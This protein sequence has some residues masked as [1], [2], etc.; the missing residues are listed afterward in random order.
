MSEEI[1]IK[2]LVY[3]IENIIKIKN[4]PKE[5]SFNTFSGIFNGIQYKSSFGKGNFANV[6]WI[7]FLGFNQEV[8][9]GIYPAILYNTKVSN[10]NFEICYGIS[11][12]NIPTNYW[13]NKFIANLPHSTTQ[14]Y[15]AS[16]LKKAYTINTINDLK[17]NL[18]NILNDIND[19]LKDFKENFSPI[20]SSPNKHYWLY[21]AGEKSYK[22]DEFYKEGI[23]ALNWD[24]LGNL[25]NYHAQD[26]IAKELQKYG[27]QDSYPMNNSK[28]NWE[29]AN[30]MNIGDIVYVKKGLEPILLGRG[31]V[32]SDYIYDDTRN[33][34]KSIRKVNWTHNGI[35]NVDFNELDIKQWNQ[36]TLN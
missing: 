8:T 18:S 13:N 20:Q 33:E 25:K 2:N 10:N 27:P 14:N 21:A 26:E 3:F 7:V 35:Y 31:V 22:W 5:A 12:Y 11:S 24:H 23:M 34:Y 28:A 15:H 6:P 32:T 36:K 29:F 30:E 4:N 19:I 16:F 17:L 9:K 1:F